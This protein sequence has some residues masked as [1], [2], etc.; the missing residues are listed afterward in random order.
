MVYEARDTAGNTVEIE[1]V[2][3]VTDVEEY[4]RQPNPAPD[5]ITAIHDKTDITGTSGDD[6]L[7]TGDDASVVAGGG[8]DDAITLGDGADIVLY[9]FASDDEGW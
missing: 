1:L 3:H 6:I 7:T 4:V 9:R 5:I 8:G 2:V